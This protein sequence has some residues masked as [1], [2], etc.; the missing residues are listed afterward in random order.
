MNKPKTYIIASETGGASFDIE[1]V[2]LNEERAERRYI[3][4]SGA[5]SLE[6]AD[7]E[8]EQER[9]HGDGTSYY[10]FEVEIE[11]FTPLPLFDHAL[12]QQLKEVE[13]TMYELVEFIEQLKKAGVDNHE[14][15]DIAV[16]QMR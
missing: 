3:A 1:A 2:Y 9:Q 4:M 16:E 8:N 14:G 11:D 13:A 5:S 15:W 6:E 10:L 7:E 12:Q